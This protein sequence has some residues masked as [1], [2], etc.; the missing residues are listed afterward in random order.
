M[1]RPSDERSTSGLESALRDWAA[2]PPRLHASV[3]RQRVLARLPI[4]D[5]AP[6]LWRLAPAAALLLLLGLAAWLS[7][8]PNSAL[9]PAG[10]LTA[11]AIVADSNVVIFKLDPK[12]T[13]YFVLRDEAPNPGGIS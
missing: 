4:D 12:T 1:S 8:P 3:A 9:S 5:R 13:V 2:R 10:S 11:Q 7:A 6:S